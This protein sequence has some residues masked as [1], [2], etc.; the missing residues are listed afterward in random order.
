[1]PAVFAALK[2]DLDKTTQRA[3]I[4]P[5]IYTREIGMPAPLHVSAAWT[6]IS[7]LFVT[8]CL[9]KYSKSIPTDI[10]SQIAEAALSPNTASPRTEPEPVDKTNMYIAAGVTSMF[11]PLPL[12]ADVLS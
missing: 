9:E 1:M 2:A 3:E 5:D 6:S 11:N 8:V 10:I 4:Q 7:E 12:P